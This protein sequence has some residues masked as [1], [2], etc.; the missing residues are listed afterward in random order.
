MTQKVEKDGLLKNEPGNS[1][2]TQWLGFCSHCW[3][4][5]SIPGTKILQ[6]VRCDRVG[7]TKGCMILQVQLLAFTCFLMIQVARF[8][9]QSLPL[10]KIKET[11]KFFCE[12]ASWRLWRYLS[13]WPKQNYSVFPQVLPDT[14]LRRCPR[15]WVA[16][17]AATPAHGCRVLRTRS[18]Q[19]AWFISVLYTQLT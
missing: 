17:R 19:G 3:S 6:A 12:S 10:T 9:D 4:P 15:W 13:V 8:W 1:P 5:S 7:R 14:W 18:S 16:S 11:E 2:V